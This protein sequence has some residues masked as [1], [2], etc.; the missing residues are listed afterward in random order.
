MLE[1]YMDV[2]VCGT[3]RL[4]VVVSFSA[5]VILLLIEL[6]ESDEEELDTKMLNSYTACKLY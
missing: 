1:A 2:V 3:L 4:I 6:V 5:A